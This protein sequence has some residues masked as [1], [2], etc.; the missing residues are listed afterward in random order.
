MSIKLVYIYIYICICIHIYMYIYI[1]IYI[2]RSSGVATCTT[3][4]L[5]YTI[6]YTTFLYSLFY[7]LCIFLCS[8]L[9]GEPLVKHYLYN[10][11]ALQTWRIMWQIMV[12]FD[13]T[14]HARIK[15]TRS[16]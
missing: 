4:L 11:C 13:T 12:I 16:Y 14:K 9:Y 8:L 15:N 5:H 3:L 6:F 7:T 10:T 1:Y 2:Y